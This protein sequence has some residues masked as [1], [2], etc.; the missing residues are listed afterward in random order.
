MQNNG[1]DTGAR[2]LPSPVRDREGRTGRG[3]DKPSKAQALARYLVTSWRTASPVALVVMASPPERSEKTPTATVQRYDGYGDPQD[4]AV[5]AAEYGS[6]GAYQRATDGAAGYTLTG[7]RV[8][9]PTTG[10]FLQADPV[11]G[12]NAYVY[13]ADPITQ[14]GTSG[15]RLNYRDQQK[16][17]KNYTLHLRRSCTGHSKCSITWALRL[18]SI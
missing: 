3:V 14:L 15:S 17:T 16:A 18:K 11:Y 9:D 8:Y 10:R 6:L 4:A 13:P 2:H 1:T 5:A 7:V 12:G